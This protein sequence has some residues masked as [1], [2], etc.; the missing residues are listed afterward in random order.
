MRFSAI[1]EISNAKIKYLIIFFSFFFLNHILDQSFH[2]H[3]T[4]EKK[5]FDIK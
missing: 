1:P 5:N 3:V 4:Y 2:F